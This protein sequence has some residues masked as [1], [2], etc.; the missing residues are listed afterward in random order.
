M[1]A[2]SGIPQNG[3]DNLRDLLASN[4]NTI[5][6]LFSIL[7]SV[8]N[9]ILIVDD[10]LIVR[11]IN[12]EY[13]L[14]TGVTQDQIIG[15]LLVE[16]RP[17]AMLPE[18]VRTGKPISGLIRKEKDVEYVVDLAPIILDNTIKGGIGVFK[19]ITEIRRLS[20]ELQRIA[21]QKDRLKSM[22][23]HAYKAAYT[24]ND[25][26][27]SSESIQKVIHFAKKFA[28]SRHDILIT[29]ESGTGKRSCSRYSFC[30]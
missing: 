24:F 29:G 30:K 8:N 22:V 6:W 11:Y 15:R 21:K 4:E 14:I 12:P 9:G 10:S 16:V 20:K 27:G 5:H 25:I 19:D 18:V 13:S 26:I 1:N 2:I 28:L 7:N 17:G 3:I 23:Q